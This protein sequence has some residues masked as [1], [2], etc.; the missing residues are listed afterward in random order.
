MDMKPA[1]LLLAALYFSAAAGMPYLM[2]K[3]AERL[4]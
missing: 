2:L 4:K 3:N 1:I